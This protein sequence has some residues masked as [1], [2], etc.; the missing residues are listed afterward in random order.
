M[1]KGIDV[2]I[3]G[4]RVT[5]DSIIFGETGPLLFFFLVGSK[6]ND[7][8]YTDIQGEIFWRHLEGKY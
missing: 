2:F 3:N 6:H 7:L 8:L 5:S 1:V 4:Q